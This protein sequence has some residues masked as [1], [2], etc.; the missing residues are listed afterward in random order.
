M[1]YVDN[2]K[3]RMTV[4]LKKEDEN[5]WLS[6]SPQISQFAFPYEA[7]LIAFPTT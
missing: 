2:V 4:M 6:G 3:K 5:K 7:P 1:R